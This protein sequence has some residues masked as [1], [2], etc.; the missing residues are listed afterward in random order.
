MTPSYHTRAAG[1]A[2][3]GGVD[4]ITRELL[5]RLLAGRRPALGPQALEADFL[6]AVARFQD[7]ERN[8]SGADK[9]W[10]MR[11]TEA[12]RRWFRRIKQVS[13]STA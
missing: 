1:G 4:E 8:Q 7:C 12:N 10:V 6:A 3:A 5:D 2:Y 9:S 11:C 13:S